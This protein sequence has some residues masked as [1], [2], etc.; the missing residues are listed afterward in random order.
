MKYLLKIE[1]IMLRGNISEMLSLPCS[2][3]IYWYAD[4]HAFYFVYV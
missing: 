1:F 3:K 2:D 4:V